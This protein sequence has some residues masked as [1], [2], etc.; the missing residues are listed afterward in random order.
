[1]VKMYSI[2]ISV[3]LLLIIGCTEIPDKP[4]RNNPYEQGNSFP[5]SL[6]VTLAN[7][8][9]HLTWTT[10]SVEYEKIYI[11]RG[12]SAHLDSMIRI[13]WVPRDSTSYTDRSIRQGGTYYYTIFAANGEQLSEFSASAVIRI[14]TSPVMTIDGDSAYTSIRNV[15]ITL[16]CDRAISFWIGSHPNDPNGQWYPMRSSITYRLSDGR[17]R[18]YVYCRFHYLEGDT[19]EWVVDSVDTSP[20]QASLMRLSA[21]EFVNTRTVAIR[22]QQI[23][24][25][26]IRFSEDSTTFNTP[27]M[28]V[29]D[30][31]YVLLSNSDGVKRIYAQVDNGFEYPILALNSLRY[32][33]DREIRIIN[34][35]ENSNGNVLGLNDRVLLTIEAGEPNAF[36]WIKLIDQYGNSRDSIPLQSLTNS[37]IYQ[38]NYLVNYGR[39]IFQGFVIGYLL[40]H[41]GNRA[42]D[43]ADTRIQIDLAQNEMVLMNANGFLMGS[44]SGRNDETP[45]HWVELPAFYLDRFEVTNQ[46]YAIFLS[47]APEHSEFW[48][49]NMRIHQN[50]SVYTPWQGFELHPVRFVT[51][52]GAVAFARW[53]GKRLP[54]EAEWEYAAKGTEN[55]TYPWG[56]SG[57]IHRQANARPTNPNT[58]R[59]GP[60]IRPDT[61]TTPVGFYNG[62]INMGYQTENGATPEGIHDLGGNVAEWCQDWYDA[63]YYQYSPYINPQG[64]NTGTL[65]VLRGGAFF[66]TSFDLRSAARFA[67]P[68]N[69]EYYFVG[70]RCASSILVP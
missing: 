19:S 37:V 10:P 46:S 42:I 28:N 44:N 50:G 53:A 3:L 52:H 60:E 58:P 13:A 21:S 1:M 36:A 47:S 22:V 57:I 64:P 66:Q 32:T 8:G 20:I 9:A 5:F 16:I 62:Q 7:G 11:Y 14:R 30:T 65:K 70:F 27:W 56:F 35:R 38:R 4:S 33:L 41:A 25:T 15:G 49:A 69:T 63:T 45:L 17:G 54:T 55:R 31:M 6:Q 67:L 26:S 24:V 2:A 23:G 12:P 51:Y 29:Q 39:N 40:D 48:N 43:T 61:T 18:K 59:P 34:V 68:P